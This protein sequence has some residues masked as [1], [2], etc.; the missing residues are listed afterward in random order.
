MSL[1]NGPQGEYHYY[2]QFTKLSATLQ[3]RMLPLLTKL[4]AFCRKNDRYNRHKDQNLPVVR[5]TI[6]DTEAATIMRLLEVTHH[7]ATSYGHSLFRSFVSWEK[8]QRTAKR[9][10]TEMASS[11]S[12]EN[13]LTL[14][15]TNTINSKQRANA[16]KR[17]KRA[18][19]TTALQASRSTRSNSANVHTRRQAMANVRTDSYNE[20]TKQYECDVCGK[21]FDKS[22]DLGGHKN[23]CA[24]ERQAKTYNQ[25]AGAAGFYDCNKCNRLFQGEGRRNTHQNQCCYKGVTHPIEGSSSSSTSSSSSSSNTKNTKKTTYKTTTTTCTFCA[26]MYHQSTPNYCTQN[27]TH[28]NKIIGQGKCH[29]NFSTQK[30][31]EKCDKYVTRGTRHSCTAINDITKKWKCGFCQLRSRTKHLFD[32]AHDLYL[33]QQKMHRER[34]I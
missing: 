15:N 17:A 24:K 4:S 27:I 10:A 33:H 13:I 8:I 16:T 11:N 20:V 34:E 6:N 31:C 22:T 3:Q 1:F 26:K 5:A 28:Y 25:E 21:G 14:N 7:L 9:T 18:A 29:P 2:T 12:N 32:T 23:R 19:A 30:V